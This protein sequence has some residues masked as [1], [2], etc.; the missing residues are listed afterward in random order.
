MT[1]TPPPAMRGAGHVPDANPSDPESADPIV[2]YRFTLANERTFLAWSRTALG[3]LAAGV[4]VHQLVDP[5]RM[6]IV[7]TA[8]AT[9]C[10]ILAV[11]TALGAYLRWRKVAAA[12]HAGR[13]LPPT[14]LIPSLTAGIAIMTGLVAIG[15]WLW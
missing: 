5:D 14:W 11:V 2:D 4:A 8:L 10:T 13:A 3:L 1:D 9:G 12:M 6:T 15:L 7:R